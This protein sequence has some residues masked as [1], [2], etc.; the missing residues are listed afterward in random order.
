[1]LSSVLFAFKNNDRNAVEA[2]ERPVVAKIFTP[3]KISKKDYIGK[4]NNF[5]VV[6]DR[7]REAK[8]TPTIYMKL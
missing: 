2:K 6:E 4:K 5:I 7:Y 3:I 1:M 8:Y